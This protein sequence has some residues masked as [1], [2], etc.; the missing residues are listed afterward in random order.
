MNR[1]RLGPAYAWL[2][3]LAAFAGTVVLAEGCGSSGTPSFFNGNPPGTDAS[4]PL[5]DSGTILGGDAPSFGDVIHHEAGP[6]TGLQC[7]IHSCPNGGS[8]TITGTIY[9]PAAKSPLYGVVVYIPN[10][11]PSPLVDGVQ[12]S[13][14]NCDSLFSGEPI[15]DAITDTA[16]K[17]T[18]QN[19]PDGTDIPLVIQIGKWRT[20]TKISTVA[21]CTDNRPQD[22]SLTLPK[23]HNVGDIPQIAVS[24]GALDTLECL[25]RR[26]GL[27]ESEYTG[28]A[29]GAGHIHIF[30]GNGPTMGGSTA[31]NATLWNATASLMPYDIVILSCEGAETTGAGGALSTQEQQNLLDYANAGGRVFASHFHYAWFDTGPMGALNLATW[32]TGAN[33]IGLVNATIVTT[34][35]NGQPFPKG[36]GLHDWLNNV[37]ALGVN[38]APPNELPIVDAKH[39]ADVSAANTPSQPWILPDQAA[40]QRANATM[41]FSFNTP[42]NAPLDDAGVPNYC[43]RVVFSDLHVGAASGDTGG[44]IGQ[45]APAGDCNYVDLSPQEKA[46]EFMLF[47][48]SSC[49]TINGAPPQGPPIVVH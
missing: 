44:T 3:G 16:G 7:Q 27:D 38:G 25:L 17:F 14:C 47:D 10:S 18:I 34:L 23:N 43:G 13:D 9:D 4:S 30:T 21:P 49:V 33:T 42:V 29:G 12:P 31:S 24:T 20:Q 39:N 46:L 22:K 45:D 35:S 1:R 26:V 5:D 8:T 19:A 6:C 48:L 11:T 40:A 15:A 36:Q 37:H 2:V 41:Y 32:S 28:G